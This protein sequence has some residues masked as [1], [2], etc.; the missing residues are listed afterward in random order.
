[1]PEQIWSSGMLITPLV[2][3]LLGL[4]PY[5]PM[6]RLRLAPHLPPEWPDVKIRGL[7][8]GR[9]T[10]DLE[11]EQSDTQVTLKAESSG[12]PVE[13]EFAPQ[14]PL[15]SGGEGL[16]AT[17][18]GR[19]HPVTVEAHAQDVHAVVKFSVDQKTELTITYPPGVRPWV[20]AASLHIGDVSRGLRILSSRLEGHTYQAELE[21]VP[22]VCSPFEIFTPWQVKQVTGGKV[23]AHQGSKWRLI[24][25]PTPEACNPSAEG[26][27]QTWTLQVDFTP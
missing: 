20:P 6:S 11:M 8:I 22:A 16:R 17:L 23:S 13:I 26:A 1:V 21:G 27:A 12:A 25:S 10:L 18:H 7:R 15:G 19:R 14:I 9:S 5:A 24:A 2:R 4:E 3:G